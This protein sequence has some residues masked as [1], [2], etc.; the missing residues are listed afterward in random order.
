MPNNN[1]IDERNSN[2]QIYINGSFYFRD[3]AK[4]SVF[5]SGFLFFVASTS[6]IVKRSFFHIEKNV[7][8]LL[9][10]SKLT[11]NLGELRQNLGEFR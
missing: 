4:I 6:I 7:E 3:D 10:T 8:L 2:I 11:R 5:D 1:I 9:G